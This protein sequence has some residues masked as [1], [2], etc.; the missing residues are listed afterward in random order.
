MNKFFLLIVMLAFCMACQPQSQ[1]G[2]VTRTELSSFGK[3]TN[4]KKAPIHAK[5][6]NIILLIGDGM[7]I[8]QISAGMYMNGNHLNLE[9][10]PVIGLHKS[11]SY[12][13]LITDS[14]AGATAFASGVKTYNGAIGVDHDTIA[15]KTILEIAEDRGKATGLVATSTI[16]HATPAAFIS[17]QKSRKLYEDIAADFL[18]TEVDFFVGGGKRF[19]DRRDS[20]ERNLYQELQDNDYYVSDYFKEDLIQC[21]LS[22]KKNFAYFTADNDPLQVAQGRD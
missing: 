10:L 17:H 15:V 19:F 6:K 18:K 4:Q 7:G 3:L 11:Y 22:W 16:V 5:P 2:E 9:Q 21:E 14:A 20:D 8:S 1:R 13:N 12:D